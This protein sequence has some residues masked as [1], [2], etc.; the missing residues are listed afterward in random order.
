[1]RGRYGQP[2]W[3]TPERVA[4]AIQEWD[5]LGSSNAAAAELTRRWGERVTGTQIRCAVATAG[6]RLDPA[7]LGPEVSG[8]SQGWAAV[9][10]A[11]GR[12]PTLDVI[13]YESG[14]AYWG[15]QR[16]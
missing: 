11:P 14:A 3:W 1:M 9:Q 2:S 6:G 12:R 4:E 13:R 8:W 10:L 16:I 5:R 15:G 7:W